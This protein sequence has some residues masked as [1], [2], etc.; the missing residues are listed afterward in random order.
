MVKKC[1][2]WL[3]DF[4]VPYLFERRKNVHPVCILRIYS[5]HKT[6]WINLCEIVECDLKLIFEKDNFFNWLMYN[7]QK[8]IVVERYQIKCNGHPLHII[9]WEI[10]ADD[11]INCGSQ[12]K[13]R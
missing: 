13:Y 9:R 11:T 10:A 6:F 5:V 12:C 8:D 1:F 3:I 7:A 2:E 4:L